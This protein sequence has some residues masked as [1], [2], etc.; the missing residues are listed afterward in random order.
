MIITKLIIIVMTDTA[1]DLALF[2]P[3]RPRFGANIGIPCSNFSYFEYMER[4]F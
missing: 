1:I 3:I 2:S 4:R